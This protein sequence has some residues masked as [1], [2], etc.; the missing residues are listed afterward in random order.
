MPI[1]ICAL[2]PGTR[3][4]PDVAATFRTLWP[5]VELAQI[6][7]E[8]IYLDFMVH[9]QGINSAVKARVRSLL[10]Q[11]EAAD[12]KAI[13]FTGS[14]FGPVL[15]ELQPE[16]SVPIVTTS[17]G[18]IE[19]AFAAGRRFGI[20][21]TFASS[22]ADLQRDIARYAAQNNLDYTTEVYVASD[23]RPLFEK[24]EREAHDRIVVAAAER[25]QNVDALLLP[26]FSLATAHL[27]IPPMPGRTA[28]CASRSCIS[29]LKRLVA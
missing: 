27:G 5:E 3:V 7:D 13:L 21:A 15:E 29:R 26:Q 24:G 19:E 14:L 11:A 12:A 23:A 4:I 2:S 9:K 22:I 6:A 16:I 8:S 10:K 20:L 25:F 1:R 18:L 28:L 17:Q